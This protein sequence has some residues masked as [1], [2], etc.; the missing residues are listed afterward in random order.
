MKI[1]AAVTTRVPWGSVAW[2]RTDAS[3]RFHWG[4][5]GAISSRKVCP[6]SVKLTLRVVRWS[7]R[8]PRASSR[9]EIRADTVLGESFSSVA[10]ARKDRRRATVSKMSAAGSSSRWARV[11]IGI[12]NNLCGSC[13]FSQRVLAPEYEGADEPLAREIPKNK[14][15]TNTYEVVRS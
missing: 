6:A 10:A 8:T 3:A 7:K 5:M 11:L 2:A 9:A 1:S 12:P 14:M 4:R 13:P 15:K